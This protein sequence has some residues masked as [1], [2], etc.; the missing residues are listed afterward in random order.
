MHTSQ[1]FSRHESKKARVLPQSFLQ[2][3]QN[4]FDFIFGGGGRF[5]TQLFHTFVDC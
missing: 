2:F 3:N 4:L 5:G 1:R